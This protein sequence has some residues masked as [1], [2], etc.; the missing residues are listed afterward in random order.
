M[1]FLREIING[2]PF[3]VPDI[4]TFLCFTK[5]IICKYTV[6]DSRVTHSQQIG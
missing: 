5:L 2:L 1:G 6:C 3:E 4:I